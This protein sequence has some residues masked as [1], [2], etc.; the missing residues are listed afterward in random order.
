MKKDLSRLF[1]GQRYENLV[2]RDNPFD[3]CVFIK[4]TIH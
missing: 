4:K 3:N 2:L 1:L